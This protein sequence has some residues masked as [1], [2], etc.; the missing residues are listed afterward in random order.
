MK[1]IIFTAIALLIF[2]MSCASSEDGYGK[3]VDPCPKIAIGCF[4]GCPDGQE[5]VVRPTGTHGC[6]EASCAQVSNGKSSLG[7]G[8]RQVCTLLCIQG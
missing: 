7:L 5:C 1:A 2:K 4:D 3:L 6:D 8:K